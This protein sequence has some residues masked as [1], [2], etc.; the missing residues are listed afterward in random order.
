M[1][2]VLL[3]I[4]AIISPFVVSTIGTND[5]YRFWIGEYS[6]QPVYVWNRGTLSSVQ[7]DGERSLRLHVP[8][9]VALAIPGQTN[10]RLAMSVL[11]N[12]VLEG[13]RL[14]LRTTEHDY[15]ITQQRG[16]ELRLD[17]NGVQVID[18]SRVLISTDSLRYKPGTP[19]RI[20]YEHDGQQF[21][22]AV[23]CTVF[24][25]FRTTRPATTMT[26][27]EPLGADGALLF[28]ENIVAEAVHN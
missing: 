19:I 7:R 8:T 26:L 27:V 14:F 9:R 5:P 10:F 28:L 20:A 13:V 21:R 6:T 3:G 16:I 25:P 15:T 11:G 17:R 12:E 18:G 22:I 1:G 23:G 2:M 4:I 24:G